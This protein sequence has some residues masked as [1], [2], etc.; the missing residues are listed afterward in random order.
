MGVG[1]EKTVFDAATMLEIHHNTVRKWVSLLENKGYAIKREQRGKIQV[2]LLGEEDI[3]I[4]RSI[5]EATKQQHVTLE[6][7]VTSA[8]AATVPQSD[9]PTADLVEITTS[10]EPDTA[11]SIQARLDIHEK[12]LEAQL[13]FN[14]ELVDRLEQS[15]KFMEESIKRRDQQLTEVLRGLIEAAS[16]KPEGRK[17]KWWKLGK[18]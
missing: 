6:Q 17:R 5:K 9:E 2:K 7:A 12:Q 11:T 3:N 8:M 13:A 18:K 1:N 4:L 14:K 15:Q 10:P 16:A